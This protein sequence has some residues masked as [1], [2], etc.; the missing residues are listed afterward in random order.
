MF[1]FQSHTTSFIEQRALSMLSMKSF[2]ATRISLLPIATGAMLLGLA[3]SESPVAASQEQDAQVA[4][5]SD[6][7]RLCQQFIP[8]HSRIASCLTRHRK[9]LSPACHSVLS[10]TKKKQ[11]SASR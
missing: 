3:L 7:M 11:H 1:A 6:V 10:K 4:C 9:D 2:G 8:D 5:T